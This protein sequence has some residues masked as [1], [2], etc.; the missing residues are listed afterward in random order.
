[1]PEVDVGGFVLGYFHDWRV[2]TAGS[3][4]ERVALQQADDRPA[5]R[6]FKMIVLDPHRV[7]QAWALVLALVER[8]PDDEALAFVAAG[9]LEDIVRRHGDEFADRIVDRARQDSKFRSALKGVW[10]WDEVSATLRSRVFAV[11][12]SP[13]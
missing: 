6:L 2:L 9:P 5:D 12:G 3:R 8:A 10:G 7:D 11:L 13:S 4:A 1:M